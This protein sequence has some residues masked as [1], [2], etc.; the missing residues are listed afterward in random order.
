MI[1]QYD[2]RAEDK[3]LEVKLQT[4][5]DAMVAAENDPSKRATL[6][7]LNAIHRSLTSNTAVTHSVKDQLVRLSADF[8]SHVTG[9]VEHSK[10]EEALM[11]KGRGVWTALTWF[12]VVV[13]LAGGVVIN[14]MRTT[15]RE[16]DQALLTLQ[17][18][19]AG[20]AS[21]LETS[22]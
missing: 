21:Q 15:M 6:M 5:L 11:N 13:Q 14:D 3:R 18:S 22:K 10:A 7:V 1:E 8:D 20:M 16:R 2:R 9:F 12:V 19:V 4:E 17:L